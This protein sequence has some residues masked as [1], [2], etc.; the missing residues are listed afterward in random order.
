MKHIAESP[1]L[2]M[3]RSGRARGAWYAV[4]TACM[5]LPIALLA[6][7][8]LGITAAIIGFL[9]YGSQA[10]TELLQLTSTIPGLLVTLIAGFL[11]IYFLCWLWVWAFERRS[12]WSLGLPKARAVGRYATGA[13]VGLVMFAASVA[14][15]GAPGM[16]TFEAESGG[17]RGLAAFA[18]IALILVGWVVQGAAEEVLCRGLI[19]PVVGARFG[20]VAGVVVSSLVF[21]LLHGINPGITALAL[22]NLALF[23]VFTAVYALREGG[24]WGVC[25]L[26]STWNWAQGNIFGLQVSGSDSS[27]AT[28]VDLAENGP[29]WFTGGSFGPEGGL[30]V[31]VVLLVATLLAYRFVGRAATIPYLTRV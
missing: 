13:L 12:Y 16:L 15:V 22:L 27:P 24:I 8:P 6:Q 3:A 30:A 7:L 20:V 19:L 25:A 9:V 10:I 17:L 2:T 1:L 28:I 31:T 14:L 4:L 26:H 23:G 11:P 18:P 21:A 29:D 5:V